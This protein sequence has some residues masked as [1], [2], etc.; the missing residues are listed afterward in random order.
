MITPNVSALLANAVD[1]IR[2]GIEDYALDKPARSLSAVR[3][4]YAGLLLLA[5]EVI[6]RKVPDTDPDQVIGAKYKPVPDGR[7]GIK[8]VPDGHSTIDFTTIGRRFKDFGITINPRELEELNAIRNDIEHRYTNKPASVVRDAIARAFPITLQLFREAGE[9]P[10]TL[11]GETWSVML[12]ARGLYE[13]ELARCRATL[14]GVNWRSPTVEAEGLRCSK[15]GSELVEQRDPQNG[16]QNELDLVC[17]NCGT[18]LDREEEIV[19][20][21]DRALSGEAYMRYKDTF[22][23][24]PVY[25]CPACGNLAYI[26]TEDACAVCGET[27]EYEATCM[28]CHSGIPLEDALAGFDEGLCSYCTHIMNKDD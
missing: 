20:A 26:D 2:M 25:E 5:K 17:Q 12:D 1:S 8:Y 22:E 19:A 14:A 4:F 27:F 21:V 16:D 15:C 9:D 28:R 7:G 24:G 13:A 11:L 18:S 3:N 23:S 6:S 10:R